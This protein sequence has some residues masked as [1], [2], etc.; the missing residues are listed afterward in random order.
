M[1][2]NASQA[3]QSK[4]AFAV[5]VRQPRMTKK[6]TETFLAVVADRVPSSIDA[7]SHAIRRRSMHLGARYS[8]I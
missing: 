5:S 3:G 7:K 1:H 8:A 4:V 6:Q 2:D